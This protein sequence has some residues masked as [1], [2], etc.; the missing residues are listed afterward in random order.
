MFLFNKNINKETN[1]EELM[2]LILKG[3][4]LAF[5]LLYERYF[6]KL[7][8]YANGYLSDIHLSEDL[9]QEVFI[10]IIESPQ[11]FNIEK[12]FSTWVYTLTANLA[13]NKLREHNTRKS[14]LKL[15]HTS[16]QEP[17]TQ[18]QHTLDL[19]ITEK[20][21][22]EIFDSLSEK[23]KDIYHLRFN[24]K[25]QIKE[26]AATMNLPEGSV[27]SGIYYLL[28]KYAQLLN[29]YTYEK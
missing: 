6:D 27:K 1:D 3:H 17:S 16:Q 5:E 18:S 14:F 24:E 11:R 25:M 21:M 20:W 28:K 10:K 29:H 15:N 7:V 9:V 12:R 4:K 23:E 2:S 8:W 13:K 22:N 19:K 26:I